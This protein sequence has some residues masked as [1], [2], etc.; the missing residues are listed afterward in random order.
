MTAKFTISIKKIQKLLLVL[1]LI[2]IIF[3]PQNEH[4]GI[5]SYVFLLYCI[6]SLNH[7]NIKYAY[8]PFV[9][10]LIW[11]ISYVH[12]ILIGS[13]MDDGIAGWYLNSCLFL[14]IIPFASGKKI[15]FIYPF[16][17]CTLVYS[18]YIIFLVFFS[19]ANTALTEFAVNHIQQN[20]D[21]SMFGYRTF[22][23]IK[24]FCLYHRTS[25]ICLISEACALLLFLRTKKNKYIIH[26]VLFFLAL[27][28]SGARANMLSAIF[29]VVFIILYK[30]YYKVKNRALLIPFIGLIICIA[31][32]VIYNVSTESGHSNDVKM[33]HIESFMQLFESNPL[34]YVLIGT[35]P[36]S[37]MYSIGI[38]QSVALTELSYFELIKNYG[39]LFTI[40]I[41]FVFTIPLKRLY[42]SENDNNSKAALTIAYLCF[43]FVA[44]T[45]PLFSGS[46]GFTTVICMFCI[47]DKNVYRE[48]KIDDYYR[49][50]FPRIKRYKIYA[51]TD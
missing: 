24:H 4:F 18:I 11:I 1:L 8:V 30:C 23:G 48:F 39:L 35:G 10:L 38:K 29:I 12:G 16:Y 15:N 9:Y 27:L 17:Y 50:S 7:F 36:G 43:F 25:S 19:M 14:F 46:T 37:V 51:R 5:K 26:F 28:Y 47:C 31:V 22:L 42:N 33:G 40:T 34:R 20:S 21:F 13:D 49:Y 6:F 3:D 2:S 41:L 45:N 32:V 44:G